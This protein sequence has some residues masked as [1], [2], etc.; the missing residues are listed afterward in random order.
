MT[1]I[2]D[3]VQIMDG[4]LNTE[5]KYNDKNYILHRCVILF[6]NFPWKFELIQPALV[7]GQVNQR[8]S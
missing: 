7:K 1:I 5:F 4:V 3:K 8:K 2:T 6:L